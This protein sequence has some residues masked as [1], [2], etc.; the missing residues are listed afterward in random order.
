MRQASKIVRPKT[1]TTRGA[2]VRERAME[3]TTM[4]AA[5]LVSPDKPLTEMQKAFVKFWAEGDSI[6]TAMMRAGYN[7]QP[8]YGYRMA[9]M[10]NVLAEYERIKKAYED[11]AQM[12]RKKVMD[13][14]LEAYEMAK[15]MAEPATMVSAAREIGRMCGYYEPVKQKLEISVSGQIAVKRIESM[16][17]ED[18]IK[19]V[20]EGMA[21]M[22]QAEAAALPNPD[23]PEG[24]DDHD[25]G[26]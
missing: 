9:K 1:D 20:A 12:T 15:L 18:L 21:A 11:A 26:S 16:S 22:Q 7:E 24:E 14:H 5:A 13:M 17:T 10:P 6:S 3:T 19:M 25:S 2:A 8:S 23:D 4:A